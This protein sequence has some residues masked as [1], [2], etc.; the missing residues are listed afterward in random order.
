MGILRTR[1]LVR[2]S[3]PFAVASI[4]I[5]GLLLSLAAVMFSSLL[6]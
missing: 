5:G 1:G 6:R 2:N 4:V 3:D